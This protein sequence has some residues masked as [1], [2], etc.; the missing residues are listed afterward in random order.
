MFIS[1]FIQYLQH[2]K[3]YSPHTITAYRKDLEQFYTYLDHTYS[4]QRISE[5]NYAFI[6]SW[7]VDLINR[8]ITGNSVNRKMAA[9]KSYYKYLKREGKIVN[10]ISLKIQSL[11]QIKKLPEFVDKE[12]MDVLFENVEFPPDYTGKR[13]KLILEILYASGIRLSELISLKNT[14][15]DLHNCTFKVT[16]K[17][18]KER[19]IPFNLLIK[20]SIKN[21]FQLKSDTFSGNLKGENNAFFLTEKGNKIYHKLV[22]RIVNK[23]LGL[24]S[25]LQKKSPHILRHTFATHLLNNGADINAIKELLGHS[26]LAATQVYTHNTI[27]K[28][29][30]VYKQAH[31]RAD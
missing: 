7:M 8:K 3:R 12:K 18:N 25:T 22:Y 4:I 10:N 11:K 27:E 9:L 24:I 13:D 5:V 30:K 2:E 1:N 6:R 26:S 14:D 17:R 29:K 20:D 16:G 28:L 19:I 23:Y 31:P 15:I 21:Y